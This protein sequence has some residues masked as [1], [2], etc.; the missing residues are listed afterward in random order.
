MITKIDEFYYVVSAVTPDGKRWYSAPLNATLPWVHAYVNA[1][2]YDTAEEAAEHARNV[3]DRPDRARGITEF[4]ICAVKREI[5]VQIT[6]YL[7]DEEA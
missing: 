6:D 2:K 4:A 1:G 3:I 7:F 5:S